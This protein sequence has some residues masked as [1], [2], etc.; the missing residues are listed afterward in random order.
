MDKNNIAIPI[1]IVVAGLLIAGGIYFGGSKKAPA[2]LGV[3]TTPTETPDVKPISKDDHVLGNPDAEVVIIEYSDLECPFCKDFHATM[4]QVMDTYG[5]DGKVAWVYR[6]YWV[7]RKMQNGAIFHPHGGDAINAAECVNEIGGNDKYWSFLSKVFDGQPSS[8]TNL[9][10]LA[11]ETGVDKTK[12]TACATS[13]KYDAK[14]ISEFSEGQKVGVAGTPTSFIVVDGKV[15]SKIPQYV[16][17][18][19]IKPLLDQ[20]VK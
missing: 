15:V 11:L 8:L 20:V 2:P 10:A 13:K 5:K 18:S 16:P 12:Y 1:S 9:T 6:N 14:M 4:K 7:E 17:F 3:G 19:D